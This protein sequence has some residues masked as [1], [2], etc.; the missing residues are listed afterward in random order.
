MGLAKVGA[1]GKSLGSKSKGGKRHQVLCSEDL[2]S[3]HDGGGGVTDWLVAKGSASSPQ[4]DVA[5]Q[6]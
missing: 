4:G 2:C 3:W 5:T 6:T 1:K